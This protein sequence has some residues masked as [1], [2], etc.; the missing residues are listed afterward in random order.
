MKRFF[1][2][3]VGVMLTLGLTG[4]TT[5]YDQTGEVFEYETIEGRDTLRIGLECDY[6]PFNWAQTYSTEY[7][8]PINGSN[9]YADG[10]DVQIARYLGTALE[11]NV[12]LYMTPWDN[13]ILELNNGN[14]DLIIAGMSPTEDR[15]EYVSFTNAYYTSE[16]VVVTHSN[17]SYADATTFADL[18]GATGIGQAETLYDDLVANLANDVYGDFNITRATPADTVPLIA[19]GLTNTYDFTVLELPVAQALLASNDQLVI[20]DITGENPFDVTDED[21][22]VSIA[23]EMDS[24]LIDSINTALSNLSTSRRNEAMTAAVARS[25]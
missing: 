15:K 10:Y 9:M 6:A 17:S 1:V 5:E 8:L 2:L 20:L 18:S 21:R 3:V 19:L 13:L 4:C 14:I 7:T 12:E 24:E 23:A 16:F 22:T 11:M 25:S